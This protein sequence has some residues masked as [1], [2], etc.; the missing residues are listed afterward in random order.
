MERAT[1]TQ[2]S[3]DLNLLLSDLEIQREG[4]PG[5]VQLPLEPYDLLLLEGISHCLPLSSVAPLGYW[6]ESE[7]T[8]DVFKSDDLVVA[9]FE[10]FISC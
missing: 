1:F 8:H 9:G 3:Y 10:C 2:L 4:R 6:F 5:V 7:S